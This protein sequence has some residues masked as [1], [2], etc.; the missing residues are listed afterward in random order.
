[1]RKSMLLL[2]ATTLLAACATD[3]DLG[4]QRAGTAES[5]AHVK[6][7]LSA[8]SLEEPSA[9]SERCD[10]S[11]GAATGDCLLWPSSMLDW[12]SDLASSSEP[13]TPF[14][15]DGPGGGSS[16]GDGD[17]GSGGGAGAGPGG[18][19]GGGASAGPGGA[20]GGGASAG[21]GGAST[22][23]GGGGAGGGAAGK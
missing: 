20:S 1:M 15:P 14:E 7:E 4:T 23:G 12:F 16:G 6:P 9:S 21:P 22:G 18:A 2:F 13:R 5:K 10:E 8:S 17:A 3:A 11:S 19:G